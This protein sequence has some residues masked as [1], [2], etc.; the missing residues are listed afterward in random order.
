MH[1][2]YAPPHTEAETLAHRRWIA[3]DTLSWWASRDNHAPRHRRTPPKGGIVGPLEMG[4]LLV[5]RPQQVASIVED[6]QQDVVATAAQIGTGDLVGQERCDGRGRS[7]S[8][9][10]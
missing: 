10:R 9:W 7:P 6:G 8:A 5:T 3:M 2:P 1:P 4:A